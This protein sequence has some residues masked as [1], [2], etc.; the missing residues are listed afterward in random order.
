[1]EVDVAVDGRRI[2]LAPLPVA[3]QDVGGP[4][5]N[6]EHGAVPRPVQV[7]DAHAIDGGMDFPAAKI[8]DGRCGDQVRQIRP[9]APRT[10]VRLEEEA[11][12]TRGALCGAGRGAPWL[13]RA[14]NAGLAIG[15]PVQ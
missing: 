14:H 2:D 13:E 6:A 7:V 9:A 4:G 15:G 5:R 12:R 11:R 8:D 10:R 3:G 1:V